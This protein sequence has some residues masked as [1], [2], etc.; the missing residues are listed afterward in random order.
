MAYWER[1]T[2]LQERT[3]ERQN[4]RYQLYQGRVFDKVGELN[5]QAALGDGK[6][7]PFNNDTNLLCCIIMG[8][9]KNADS[10]KK[11]KSHYQGDITLTNYETY[12]IILYMFKRLK[13]NPE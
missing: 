10:G 13:N 2:K 12:Q 4:P 3:R 9:D 5:Y 7:M 6:L 11:K 1:P 8:L